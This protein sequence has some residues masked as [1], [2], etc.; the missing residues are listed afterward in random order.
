MKTFE[1]ELWW[2][3]TSLASQ[4]NLSPTD[5]GR[6]VADLVRLISM[7]YMYFNHIK[8]YNH[9]NN[10]RLAQSVERETLRYH[11]FGDHVMSRD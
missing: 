6:E 11:L 2:R 1:A 8:T 10:A 9:Y 3:P 4:L 7:V 5:S